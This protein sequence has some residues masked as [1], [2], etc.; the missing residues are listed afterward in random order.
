MSLRDPFPKP[1]EYSSD[2][3]IVFARGKRARAFK[4]RPGALVALLSMVP[5]LGLGCLVL[6]LLFVFRD[7]LLA[8][9]M[10]RQAEM[11]YAYED[12]LASMR[13]QMERMKSRELVQEQAYE[14][15]LHALFQRQAQLEARATLVA[16]LAERAGLSDVTGEIPRTGAASKAESTAKAASQERTTN[17]LLAPQFSGLP[18]GLPSAATSFAP[19]TT[20]SPLPGLKPHPDAM[21]LRLAP[22]AESSE[23]APSHRRSA[24]DPD[25]EGADASFDATLPARLSIASTALDRV[26]R[27][28][29]E[30]VGSLRAPALAM[31][32]RLR[33]AL[34]ETGL[35][36]NRLTAQSGTDKSPQG[37]PFVPVELGPDSSPFARHF[38]QLQEAVLATERLRR[39]VPYVPLRKP[40]PG[41][42]ELT[43]AFG[44]RLD[45][46][47]GRPAM[48]TGIDLR[49]DYGAPVRATAAGRVVT[50]E[51]TGGYGKM[52][53][54]D[55]GNGIT[56]RY[57]HLSGISVREG[58]AVEIGTAIGRIGSTGRATGPHLHYEVRIDDE[59][60][61]PTRFLRAGAKL[62]SSG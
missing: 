56:T 46:F 57:G 29:M 55:H 54:I 53:E 48:H 4:L 27:K 38:L 31:A 41:E 52:V 13:T 14:G 18:A 60:V 34:A 9:L 5:A 21:E 47:L 7:D 61:D 30:T 3:S 16:S 59:A 17:P 44:V 39:I 28:Q 35:S 45:P 40:L 58:Q 10:S 24:L 19:V 23:S 62:A 26:E 51:W 12:R 2:Y 43:S 50:A 8:S 6:A 37:G 42:L 49:D 1:Q 36:P 33:T 25:R 32:E 15:R 20:S 11:Q 22:S